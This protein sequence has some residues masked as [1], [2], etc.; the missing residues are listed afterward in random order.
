MM[1]K[2]EKE[3]GLLTD[4][5]I[6]AVVGNMGVGKSTLCN[7]LH[8]NHSESISI[9]K[10]YYDSNRLKQFFQDGF[11][12][13]YSHELDFLYKESKKLLKTRLFGNSDIILLDRT[14]IDVVVFAEVFYHCYNTISKEQFH[15]L[16]RR[17]KLID[18]TLFKLIDKV[19]FVREP[20]SEVVWKNIQERRKRS[21]DSY[22]SKNFIINLNDYYNSQS[23]FLYNNFLYRFVDSDR[24]ITLDS[25][26]TEPPN[27]YSIMVD[28]LYKK[29]IR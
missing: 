27:Y 23:D 24:L 15:D 14:Y 5:L 21:E 16:E 20:D 18:Q 29:L 22:L 10:E 17:F 11:I 7:T 3:E 9:Q 6:V 26:T 28:S 12:G 4:L 2:E 19:I 25:I 1:V 13:A 8:Y